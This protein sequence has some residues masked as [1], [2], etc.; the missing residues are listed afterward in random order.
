M[1]QNTR[2]DE[3]NHD[4][5]EWPQRVEFLRG[6]AEIVRDEKLSELSLEQNGLS[7]QVK[8]GRPALGAPPAVS[9]VPM[10]APAAEAVWTSEDAAEE[11]ARVAETTRAEAAAALVPV[12]SPMVGVFYRAKSPDEP[13]FVEEGDHVEVGQIIGLVEAM[14]TFN[15]IMSEVEGEVAEIVAQNGQ[16]VETG[17]P[18]IQVRKL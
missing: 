18:L 10:V 9:S 12:V 4:G 3:T 8:S 6:L 14:K 17:G 11:T 5:D 7:I 13:A 2:P 16:L 15:E 1:A